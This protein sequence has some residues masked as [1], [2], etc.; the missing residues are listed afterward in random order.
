[1]SIWATAASVSFIFLAIALSTWKQLGLERDLFIGMIRAAIQLIAVGYVLSFVF[2]SDHW[3]FIVL[4]IFTMILVA[5]RN[6]ASRGQGI[7]YVSAYIGLT[8]TTVTVITIG[9]ML[10]LH[11]IEPKPQALIPISGMVIG[12]CMTTCSLLV[13]QMRQR[14]QL[15]QEQIVV[16]LSLGATARQAG[17]T[18]L[19]ESVRAGMIPTIDALKTVGLVQLPG[20]MTGLIL[21][22]ASPIEAVRYQL[23][24]MFS[25][26]SSAALTS[27][28]L[29]HLIYPTLFTSTHQFRGWPKK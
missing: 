8:I 23:L 28:M 4:M 5:T 7:P 19:R 11:T 6:A 15:M 16:A 21:A 1:M 10:I 20:M 9:L 17:V 27:M 18:L 13:N 26:A 2:A 29:G 24:I 22:G 12:S 3:L 25:L 14:V